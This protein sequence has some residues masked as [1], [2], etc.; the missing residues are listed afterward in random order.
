MADRINEISLVHGVEMQI[1]DAAINQADDLL[2]ADCCGHE[3]ARFNII[4]QAIKPAAQFGGDGCAG[5]GGEICGLFKILNRNDARHNG[6]RNS[7][8]VGLIDKPQIQV[9]VEKELCDGAGRTS[10]NFLFQKINV[11][12]EAGRFRVFFWIG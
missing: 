8:I 6:D 11:S 12:I 2:G 3:T 7:S 9:I 1:P 10:V 4:F 5:L